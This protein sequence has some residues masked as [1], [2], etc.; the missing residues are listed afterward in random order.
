[1]DA[2]PTQLKKQNILLYATPK[3]RLA[4]ALTSKRQMKWLS[5]ILQFSRMPVGEKIVYIKGPLRTNLTDDIIVAEL[6]KEFDHVLIALLTELPDDHKNQ[7][8]KHKLRELIE[9]R[10][11]DRNYRKLIKKSLLKSYIQHLM[12]QE[13]SVARFLNRIE[14]PLIKSQAIEQYLLLRKNNLT[15]N[16]KKKWLGRIPDQHTRNK[17]TR[18]ISVS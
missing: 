5:P 12:E 3:Q 15:P 16:T 2:T 1:M 8:L 11:C 18:A 14:N 4:L 7:R 10:L 6:S 9:K 17:T 13:K